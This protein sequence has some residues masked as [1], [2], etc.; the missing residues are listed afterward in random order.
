MIEY[1]SGQGTATGYLA[2]PVEANGAGVLLLHA[3]WGLK[4]FFRETCDRLAGEGFVVLAPD[5]YRGRTASTVEEAQGLMSSLDF[6]QA[7]MD[8]NGAVDYVRAHPSVTAPG[9]GAVGFSMGAALALE[10]STQRPA[11]IA[12]VVAFYGTGAADYAAANAAYLGHFGETDGWEPL[13]DVRRME[14][15]I[16]AAGREVAFHIYKGAGHWFF[17]EDRPE[18][19]AEA[20][21]LAWER[22]V[23]FLRCNLARKQG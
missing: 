14:A 8:V 3:W 4:P 19:D 6:E 22:T 16:R 1:A 5:L 2:A 9:L 17:E 12:A 13:Q 11:D 15:D 10:L 20:A 7:L 21:R 23:T 18:Y